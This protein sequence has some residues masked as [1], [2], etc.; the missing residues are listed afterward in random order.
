MV[1]VE[2]AATIPGDEG[3]QA[4]AER[5]EPV[6]SGAGPKPETTRGKSSWRGREGNH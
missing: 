5:P 3:G 4:E 6:L 2:G 1:A